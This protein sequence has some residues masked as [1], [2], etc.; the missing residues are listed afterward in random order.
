MNSG[1]R[2]QRLKHVTISVNNC[3]C[4]IDAKYM[5]PFY[6]VPAQGACHWP[7]QQTKHIYAIQLLF[8]EKYKRHVCLQKYTNSSVSFNSNQSSSRETQTQN[9]FYVQLQFISDKLL[10]SG[11][12][13]TRKKACGVSFQKCPLFSPQK[14]WYIS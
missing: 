8:S 2:Y 6:G 12:R 7:Y 11:G 14:K 3:S 13:N 4:F 9:R 1:C 5:C 10:A